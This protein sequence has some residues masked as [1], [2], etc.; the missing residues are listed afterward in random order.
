[1]EA[2]WCKFLDHRSLEANYT[3]KHDQEYSLDHRFEFFQA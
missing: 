2:M 3:R 1:M